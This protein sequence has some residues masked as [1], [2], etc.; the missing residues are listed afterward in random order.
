MQ[1]PSA[2]NQLGEMPTRHEGFLQHRNYRYLKLALVLSIFAIVFYA[3]A[4]VGQ[5]PNGGTWYGYTLGVISALLIVWL[6]LLGI[7]KRAITRGRWSLKSWTSA[8]V[9]LGMLLL[10][11]GTLHTGFQ[12]GWNVHTLAYALMVVVII[13]GFYGI[14]YYAVT[15]RRMSDNRAQTSQ[16][17]MLEEIASLDAELR[18][19]A[20]PLDQ[21]YAKEVDRAIQ[22]TRLRRGLRGRISGED[23]GCATA[24]ALRKLRLAVVTA[25]E[26]VRRPLSEILSILE[27]KDA[28]LV[29]VRRHIRYRSLLELWL[30]FHVPL[31]FALL[32]ALIAH[33]VSVFF[34]W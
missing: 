26:D 20:Q 21:T 14:Y 12:F 9:Y 7:R 25:P 17:E 13:S 1:R 2:H 3:G 28:A 5:R 24:R 19:A 31:S 27:R 23:K 16:A 4:D 8:H 34:Y 11:T 10:V 6:M 22:K 18:E 29:R 32:A 15:P 33:I 30:Y